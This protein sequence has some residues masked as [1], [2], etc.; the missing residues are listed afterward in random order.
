MLLGLET[1]HYGTD[2]QRVFYLV[3]LLGVDADGVIHQDQTHGNEAEGQHYDVQVAV[4]DHMGRV[5][6]DGEVVYVE[7]LGPLYEG[8][9]IGCVAQSD[10]GGEGAVRRSI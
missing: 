3:G 5:L 7:L 9:I 8:E 4:G 6:A 1:W 2:L 10:N